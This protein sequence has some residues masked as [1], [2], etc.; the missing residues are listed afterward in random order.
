MKIPPKKRKILLNNIYIFYKK[1]MRK[2]S[3]H[4]PFLFYEFVSRKL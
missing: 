4:L 2:N 1:K 3:K